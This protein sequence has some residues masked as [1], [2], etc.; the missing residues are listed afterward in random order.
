MFE[1]KS[2]HVYNWFIL[3]NHLIMLKSNIWFK[4]M[5]AFVENLW[6]IFMYSLRN[7]SYF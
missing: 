6:K 3:Y 4:C 2:L 7:Y 5:Y 1:M